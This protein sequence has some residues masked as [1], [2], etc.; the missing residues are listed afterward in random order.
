MGPDRDPIK[1][2]ERLLLT[3]MKLWTRHSFSTRAKLLCYWKD[4]ILRPKEFEFLSSLK[5]LL[6]NH[7]SG[8]SLTSSE[9]HETTP[10]ILLLNRTDGYSKVVSV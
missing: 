2:T 6:H 9:R 4:F 3:L 10:E 8:M 1:P 5:T 7:L